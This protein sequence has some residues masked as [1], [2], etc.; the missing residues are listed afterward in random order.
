MEITKFFLV[1]VEG[2]LSFLS[3]CIVPI[4]PVYISILSNSSGKDFEQ[5]KVNFLKTPLFRN[6]ILFIL[7]I[8]STFFILGTSINAFSKFLISNKEDIIRMGGVIIILMGLFYMGCLNIPMLQQERKMRINTEN[9]NPVTAYI[10]GITF[11]FGWTPCV[12]PMLA[13]VLIMASGA[14]SIITGNLMIAVY[15]LGFTLPFIILAAFYK[16]M[17]KYLNK[18]KQHMNEIKKIGGLILI[19][20]GIIMVLGGADKVRGYIDDMISKPSKIVEEKTGVREESNPSKD[21][22][23]SPNIDNEATGKGNIEENGIE[24]GNIG[25]EEQNALLAPDFKLVDQYGKAHSLID[26]KGKVVF[27]NFWATW[28]PP[29][30]EEMPHIEELY[31]EYNKNEEDIV[32]LGVAIPNVGRE[33]STEDIK[34]F[35]QNEGYTFPVVF[36]EDAKLLN[37]YF[38][39]AFPTTFIIGKEGNVINYIP[40]AM[41]KETM[42]AVISEAMGN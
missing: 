39:N 15:T 30:R 29:C 1:F 2:L 40:G 36:D 20:S 16:N 26:Y 7:G 9:M 18:V 33:G 3:P 4:L 27:L 34:N 6:T 13:S 37:K 32:I 10:L 25:E 35:L 12:G 41:D 21:K 42:R 5:G 17:F 19:I 22:E 28:C 11:S 38:I 8:S 14:D 31:K 23:D 24:S